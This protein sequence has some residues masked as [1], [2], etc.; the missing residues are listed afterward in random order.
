MMK[1]N[2]RILDEELS[3]GIYVTYY[4]IADRLIKDPSDTVALG[5]IIGQLKQYISR[6]LKDKGVVDY[7]NGIDGTDGLKYKPGYEN[8]LKYLEAKKTREIDDFCPSR[9]F[10]CINT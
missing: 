8:Y 4:D 6:D 7:K 3:K 1:E 9:V 2:K 10:F 5:K